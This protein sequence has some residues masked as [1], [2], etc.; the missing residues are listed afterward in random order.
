MSKYTISPDMIKLVNEIR[1]AKEQEQA[2]AAIRKQHQ[3]ALMEQLSGAVEETVAELDQH[4]DK[5]TTSIQLYDGAGALLAELT[6]VG[7]KM[8]GDQLALA[9]LVGK[10][11][12]AV[13]QLVKVDYKPIVRGVLSAMA[14]P[15]GE[16]RRLLDSAISYKVSTPTLTLK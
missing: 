8:E 15:A 9:E 6:G 3:E 7:Y 10:H 16:I 4:N 5:V 12:A 14:Q 11:P 1:S 2:W 13:G